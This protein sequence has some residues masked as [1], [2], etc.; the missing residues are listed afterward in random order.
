MLHYLAGGVWGVVIRRVL[1]AGAMAL[2]LM[3]ALIIPLLL[4]ARQIYPWARSSAELEVLLRHKAAYLNVTFFTSRSVIY[5]ALWI[6]L[7]SLFR[8]WSVESDRSNAGSAFLKRLEILSGP[9]MV[10]YAL[11]VTFAWIDWTMSLEPEWDSTISGAMIFV[12]QGLSALSIAIIVVALL[13]SQKPLHEAVRSEHFHD[14]GN[15]LLMFVML[16]TYLA[17]SQYI[18]IWS[19]NLPEEASWYVRRDTPGLNIMIGC[20]A[21]FIFLVPFLILL[22][23]DVKRNAARLAMVAAL[24]LV[25]SLI[26]TYWLVIPAFRTGFEPHISDLAAP[27]GIGGL[28][29]GLFTWNLSRQ[30]LLPSTYPAISGSA[31]LAQGAA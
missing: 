25:S 7:A 13:S 12:G 8:R 27:I 14:L 9:G 26:H 2:P 3:A 22:F 31:R 6:G 28:W 24:I 23:R 11:S 1:E 30:P 19:G 17:F 21:A 15:L 29:L 18:V 16:W 5:F 10:I 4:A 20:I